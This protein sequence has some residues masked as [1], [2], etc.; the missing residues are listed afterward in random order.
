MVEDAIKELDSM[1]GVMESLA[2]LS[3]DSARRVLVWVCERYDLAPAA[4]RKIAFRGADADASIEEF[5]DLASLYAAAAPKTETQKVLVAGYF[6]QKIKG[7]SDLDS[8]LL[9]REL[10]H[11]GHSISNIT[12]AFSSLMKQKPQLAIQTHKTGASRQ[13]R[14]KYRLTVAGLSSVENLLGRAGDGFNGGALV[15]EEAAE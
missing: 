8:G 2:Q 11:L 4:K 1:K 9:N 14:K 6:F 13:G 10:R 5:Q 7:N 12:S 3:D 15:D